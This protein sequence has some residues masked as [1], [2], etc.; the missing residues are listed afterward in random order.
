MFELASLGL[1]IVGGI[2][3]MFARGKANRE[4]RK[5]QAQDPVYQANPIAAQRMSL[6]QNLLNA[7]MPGAQQAERN[8]YQAQGNQFANINRNAT[9]ASQALALG[10]STLGQ[11]QDQFNQLGMNEA[12]DYQRR[13]GNYA[14]AGEGVINEGNKVFE[15]QTRRYGDK[16]QNV[17]AQQANNAANW[18]DVSN[19][20]FGLLDFGASG[21]FGNFKNLFGGGGDGNRQM[22]MGQNVSADVRRPNSSSYQLF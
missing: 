5:L 14:Q 11:T 8:I 20:G 22:G 16:V 4:L 7:R 17:G 1:G 9:D 6:T 10:A 21:G 18:G 15:D 19:M 13:Y 12:N 3:K 2:G